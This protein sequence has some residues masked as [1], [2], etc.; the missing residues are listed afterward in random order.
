MKTFLR[1]SLALLI[2]SHCVAT[3]RAQ[4]AFTLNPLSPPYG[5]SFGGYLTALALGR[6]QAE[7]ARTCGQLRLFAALVEE[8]S[9]VG[10]R[11][12]HADPNRNT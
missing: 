3:A 8:G 10:A 9:W 2:V 4:T 11:I 7:T 5:P 6:L 1:A 12:D